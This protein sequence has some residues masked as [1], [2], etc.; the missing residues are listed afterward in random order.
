LDSVINAFKQ[1]H[2]RSSDNKNN[3]AEAH[4]NKLYL[5]PVFHPAETH[6]DD[7]K[8]S[9]LPVGSY[10]ATMPSLITCGVSCCFE[11]REVVE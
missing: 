10:E 2:E 3:D 6:D 1:Q 5:T 7:M 11:S 8:F 9:K 4:T